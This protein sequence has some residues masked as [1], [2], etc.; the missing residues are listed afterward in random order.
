MLNL[1][2]RVNHWVWD[3]N[4]ERKRLESWQ[5]EQERLLQVHW[6]NAVYVHGSKNV[7]AQDVLDVCIYLYTFMGVLYVCSCACSISHVFVY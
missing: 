7:L 5:Q 1:A 4:E 6:W 3:P 2:K